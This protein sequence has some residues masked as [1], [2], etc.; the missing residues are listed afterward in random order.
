MSFTDGKPF[1]V[2]ELHLRL[3]WSGGKE[4]KNFRCYLCGYRFKLGDVVRWQ[5][6]ND[7]TGSPGNPLVCQAC[8]GPDVRERWAAQ[9]ADWRSE[10]FWWFRRMLTD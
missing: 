10:R 7:G 4:A 2:T 8:D 5:Y 3:P 9:W 6:T 1:V